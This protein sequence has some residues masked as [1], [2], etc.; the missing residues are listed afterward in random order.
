MGLALVQQP[1]APARVI[2][3]IRFS[4]LKRM[5]K[6]AAHYAD[7]SP[8]GETGPM[9]KGTAL[10]SYLLG[11]K[12]IAVYEGR[13]DPRMAAWKE[14]QA[15]HAG[16]TILSPRELGD[17]GGM[18]RAIENHPR[19][20]MLLDDGVQENRIE[21]D[22]AGRACAGTPDVVRPK[23]GH[24]RLVE[25]KTCNTSAPG[26]FKHKAKGMGYHAQVAWYADG[27]ERTMSYEPGSVNEV[28]IIAVESS[29]P[30]PVTVIRVCESMLLLGRKQY[31]AWFEAVRN[32]EH[33]DHFPAYAENDV[34]WED[35]EADGDGLDWSD[36]TE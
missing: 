35:E 36:D 12:A 28:F 9:R 4:R 19:A 5:S 17:V 1:S 26:L 21:W 34:D 29:S 27:C 22:L 16:K 31:R 14:F 20:R 3:P 24:K 18:R 10:H 23:N 33:V 8:W 13:R 7:A 11:G 2:E 30:Y 32:C 6:S 15:E 25:L